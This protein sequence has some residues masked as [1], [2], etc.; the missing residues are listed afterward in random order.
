VLSEQAR[1]YGAVTTSFSVGASVEKPAPPTPLSCGLL[2]DDCRTARVRSFPVT[3][4]LAT[5]CGSSSVS[6][7]LDK[8]K[9]ASPTPPREF[10]AGQKQ[11]AA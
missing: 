10:I 3:M 6:F 5:I 8:G 1:T 4:W 9:E 11:F 7:S 2:A